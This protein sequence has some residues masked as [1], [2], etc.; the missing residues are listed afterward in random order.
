MSY[1][2]IDFYYMGIL[3]SNVE[4]KGATKPTG[5]NQ[6]STTRRYIPLQDIEALRDAGC[7]WTMKY[8]YKL[9]SLRKFP[10]LFTKVGGRLLVD[11]E[12]LLRLIQAGRKE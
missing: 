9:S 10:R 12:E 7:P 8:M 4:Q 11:T 1:K 3:L 2:C 6:M 5:R